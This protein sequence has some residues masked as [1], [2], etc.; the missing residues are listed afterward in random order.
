MK[1]I[2]AG[3]AHDA[4][5]TFT[6]A[7]PRDLGSLRVT[8]L[9]G[10][11]DAEDLTLSWLDGATPITALNGNMVFQS[12]NDA[13][14]TAA[15]GRLGGLV[16]TQGTMALSKM[17]IPV[18]TVGTLDVSAM[19]SIP[20]AIAVLNA[21]PLSLLR[22]AP[23]QLA[24]ATGDV[25]AKVTAVIPFI[26]NLQLEDTG[27]HVDAGLSGVA[28]DSVVAGLRFTEG[29]GQLDVTPDGLTAKAGLQFAGEPAQLDV[30][31]NF[32]GVAGVEDIT[33]TSR[34]GPVLLNRC[35]LDAES[36]VTGSAVPYSL[37]ITGDA[38][39]TQTARLLADLT[40]AA[41]TAAHFGWSK[42]AGAAGHLR[43]T[44]TLMDGNFASLGSLDASAPGLK[45][46]AWGRVGT[47][48]SPR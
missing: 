6:L 15:S 8:N 5:F 35:G 11:F 12:G 40:P 2:T 48:C 43:A 9:T 3:T 37:R 32:T 27:L 45:F 30:K 47:C 24:Q 26:N 20:D 1:N 28:F 46:K 14:I 42:P 13:V 19:G 41:L 23:P 17:G 18:P 29:T 16:I 22:H 4:S 10:R 39:G 31:V 38:E 36:G 21:P 7:A 34:A 44:A 25:S 33:L